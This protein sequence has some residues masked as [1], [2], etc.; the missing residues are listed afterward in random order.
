[1]K[2]AETGLQY[3]ML[4]KIDIRLIKYE[5]ALKITAGQRSLTIATAFVTAKK[6]R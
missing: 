1:M 6:L 5:A 4:G 3:P 2:T